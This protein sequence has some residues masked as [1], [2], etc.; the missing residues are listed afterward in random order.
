MNRTRKLTMARHQ[1]HALRTISPTPSPE[2]PARFQSW[3]DDVRERCRDLWGSVGNRNAGR[4]EWL[5]AREVPE[6]TAIPA[7]VTI[8]QW[9]RD[10]DWESWANGELTRTRGK[11]LHQLQTTWLRALQLSQ[12]VQ[13]DAMLGRYDDNPGGGAVRVKAAE[14]VQRIV[15]QAGLLALLPAEPEEPDEERLLSLPERARRMREKF[16]A[17]NND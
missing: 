15:A 17:E 5:Y 1:E 14:S 11:T 7:S 8:R 13:L 2:P 4:V 9:A 6:G 3:L 10:D 12:E 16:A